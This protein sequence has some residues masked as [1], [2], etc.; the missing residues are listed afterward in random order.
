VEG[1]VPNPVEVTG[2]GGGPISVVYDK[3]FEGV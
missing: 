2:E 3:A 1:K